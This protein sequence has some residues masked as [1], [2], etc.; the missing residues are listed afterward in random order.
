M[1]DR[2][3]PQTTTGESLVPITV[4]L[5]MLRAGKKS[6][7]E[8]AYLKVAC[9]AGTFACGGDCG[10]IDSAR[11]IDRRFGQWLSR[12]VVTGSFVLAAVAALEMTAESCRAAHLDR[13]HETRL[14]SRERPIISCI[15]LAGRRA[16]FKG[17]L[18]IPPRPSE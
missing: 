10:S 14:G 3:F 4:V 5:G 1:A 15:C 6:R 17:F 9:D 8:K 13:S 16:T 12:Q 2:T 18:Q 7:L 11:A